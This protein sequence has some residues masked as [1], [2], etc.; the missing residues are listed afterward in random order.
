MDILPNII[1]L[2]VTNKVKSYIYGEQALGNKT[3]CL[4]LCRNKDKSFLYCVEMKMKKTHHYS[5][6]KKP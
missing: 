1:I 2:S 5:T 4:M 6:A 3:T